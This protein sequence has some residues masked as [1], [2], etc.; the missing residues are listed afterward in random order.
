MR[1]MRK[2]FADAV[3]AVSDKTSRTELL[4]AIA[5][6]QKTFAEAVK[7]VKE[8]VRERVQELTTRVELV[9]TLAKKTDADLTARCSTKPAVTDRE[10]SPKQRSF[11][12]RS[13]TPRTT[14]EALGK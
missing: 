1:E 2:A 14:G 12:H 9:A 13:S 8:D 5:E 4:A 6:M 10:V 3:S 11:Q 7:A